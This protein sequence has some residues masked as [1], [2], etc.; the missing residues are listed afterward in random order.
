MFTQ[1]H[2]RDEFKTN[3]RG[4]KIEI[5]SSSFKLHPRDG[6]LALLAEESEYIGPKH[7]SQQWP[8]EAAPSEKQMERTLMMEFSPEDLAQ[9]FNA[10]LSAGFIR[11]NVEAVRQG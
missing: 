11:V 3:T 10:A 9:L 4:H 7:N 6:K 5:S 2:A 8:F 1:I